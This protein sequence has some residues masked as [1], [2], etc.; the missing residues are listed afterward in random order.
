MGAIRTN[1]KEC[2]D[3]YGFLDEDM[4]LELPQMNYLVKQLIGCCIRP[5]YYLFCMKDK[6]W[7]TPK[8]LYWEKLLVFILH[9]AFVL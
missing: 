9:L 4:E 7:V 1:G 6:Q 5:T 2:K 8:L 3:I